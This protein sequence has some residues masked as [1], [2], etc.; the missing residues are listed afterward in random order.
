MNSSNIVSTYFNTPVK[1]AIF[2][3]SLSMGLPD[4]IPDLDSFSHAVVL[5]GDTKPDSCAE[6]MELS[7]RLN[8]ES[9]KSILKCLR[10]SDIKPIFCSSEFV[11]DGTKGD[12]VESDSVN[13][14]MAYGRQKA[15]IEE[16]LAANHKDFVVL[17]LA[18]VFGADRGD[19]TL[20]TAWLESI[21]KSQTIHCAYDQIFAPIHIDDV[22]GLIKTVIDQ[23]ING[24]YHVSTQR[25]Y[26]RLA[27]FELLVS[28]VSRYSDVSPNVIP[29]SILDL[30]LTEKRPLNVSMRPDKLITATKYKI[31]SVQQSCDQI[32]DEWFNSKESY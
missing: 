6:D 16:Y 11:F 18:K 27:L 5:Y 29:V 24:L 28:S 21:E 7:N 10:E 9:T 15:D 12:Y 13:P 23:D 32:V 22:V 3:D 8:V 25:A 26:N 14:K 19:G 30:N 2:F 20:F 31:K 17:R 4:I 1:G